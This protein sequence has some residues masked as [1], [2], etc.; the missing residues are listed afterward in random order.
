LSDAAKSDIVEKGMIVFD[1]NALLGLYRY[2]PLTRREVIDLLKKR[3]SKRSWIPHQVAVEF[4]RHRTEYINEDQARVKESEANISKA[5]DAVVTAINK[6]E[7]QKIGSALDLK[8]VFAALEDG[9][10]K[11]LGELKKVAAAY[12]D[13]TEKDEVLDF[14]EEL[15]GD[16]IGRPYEN[17][18]VLDAIY[19]DGQR[20]YE[21]GI[22][23]GFKDSHKDDSFFIESGLKYKRKFGDLLIW[24]QLLQQIAEDKKRF[25][26][27]VFVTQERKEDW[28]ISEQGKII[29][30]RV[31]LRQ[32]LQTS[33][34]KDF[35]MYS[36]A[37]FIEVLRQT[38]PKDQ[39]ES[40]SDKSLE[41]LKSA[42]KAPP[43][44]ELLRHFYTTNLGRRPTYSEASRDLLEGSNEP[45]A[46]I[47]RF[48]TS[49]GYQGFLSQELVRSWLATQY[50]DDEI[51]ESRTFPDLLVIPRGTKTLLSSELSLRG[52]EVIT[53][54]DP[55]HFLTLLKRNI[56]RAEEFLTRESVKWPNVS[57][58]FVVTLHIP[59]VRHL[60]LEGW[61]RL[62][63][64]EKAALNAKSRLSIVL[65]VLDRDVFKE[66]H[67]PT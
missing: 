40:L 15:F 6:A 5:L 30:P 61:I 21:L 43:P 42:E 4:L 22:P 37:Q 39:Q 16:E 59:A 20:R 8:G 34:I 67:L 48:A 62:V 14:V 64:A 13:L 46:P 33:G 28:W 24:K 52:Y 50:P 38:S 57:L 35:H 29:G 3:I 9:K 25:G 12:P 45:L 47:S 26:K 58:F 7:F 51:I 63:D 1:T 10:A 66:I 44:M 53:P 31:E 18:N 2:A 27:V 56:V 55:T 17:Q 49:D 23:P 32:E 54:R 36:M 19:Q 60:G 41:E 11:L 65:G